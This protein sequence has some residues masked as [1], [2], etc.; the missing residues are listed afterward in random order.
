MG[1]SLAAKAAAFR[2]ELARS[3]LSGQEVQ[4]I[5]R[6]DVATLTT[7][8]KERRLLA[9][10]HRA[11]D[12]WLYPD[13]QFD[14]G[15]LIKEIPDLLLVYETYYGHVWKNSWGIVAWFMTPHLLLDGARPVDVMAERP[16]QV[17]TV[18]RT[19]FLQDPSTFW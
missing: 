16:Q 4:S 17:L 15:A 1:T 8:R 5:L 19:E 9:V 18:A 6:V 2:S 11:A 7:W 10:W 14:D 12:E 3:Y 13:F